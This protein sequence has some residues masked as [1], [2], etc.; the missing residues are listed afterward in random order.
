MKTTK[1]I[2]HLTPYCTGCRKAL[3]AWMELCST[4]KAAAAKAERDRL[5]AKLRKQQ[6]LGLVGDE[7]HAKRHADAFAD[8]AAKVRA[9]AGVPSRRA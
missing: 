1:P 6:Q 7:R 8:F 9:D 3:P 5:A 2:D 4:C